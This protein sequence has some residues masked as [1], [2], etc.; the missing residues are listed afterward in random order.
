M[1]LIYIFFIYRILKFFDALGQFVL[2]YILSR[3]T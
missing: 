2:S 1:I 3:G